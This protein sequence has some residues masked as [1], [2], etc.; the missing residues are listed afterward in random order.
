M[1]PPGNTVIAD[2]DLWFE[3]RALPF[4]LSKWTHSAH[5]VASGG[6]EVTGDDDGIGIGGEV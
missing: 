2:S 6:P 1:K 5:L 4:L 3:T